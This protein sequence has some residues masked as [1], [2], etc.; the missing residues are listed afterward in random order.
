MGG[1]WQHVLRLLLWTRKTPLMRPMSSTAMMPSASVKRAGDGR[2]REG[3]KD[4][5]P[6]VIRWNAAITACEKGGQWL[7]VQGVIVCGGYHDEHTDVT[8]Y[9]AA[10]R[11]CEKDEGWLRALRQLHLC[12]QRL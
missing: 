4:V 12:H 11:V 7:H 10:I 5:L 1:Q 6:K 2:L 8:T 3:C 9:N